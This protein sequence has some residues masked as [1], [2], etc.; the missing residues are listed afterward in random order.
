MKHISDVLKMLLVF[1]I[2]MIAFYKCEAQGHNPPQRINAWYE[3]TGVTTDSV[4]GMP[5]T[6]TPVF[7]RRTGSYYWNTS[8]SNIY[9]WSGSQFLCA[10][11]V[12]NWDKVLSLGG[13]LTAHRNFSFRDSA[14]IIDSSN[15]I[16]KTAGADVPF[17]TPFTI[18]NRDSSQG[19]VLQSFIQ[20]NIYNTSPLSQNVPFTFNMQNVSNGDGT[21]NNVMGFGWNAFQSQSGANAFYYALEPDFVSGGVRY[22]EAHLQFDFPNG[23]DQVRLYSCTFQPRSGISTATGTW[24]FRSNTFTLSTPQNTPYFVSSPGQTTIQG[25]TPSISLIDNV[26][27]ANANFQN[28][29]NVLELGT[30]PLIIFGNSGGKNLTLENFGGSNGQSAMTWQMDDGNQQFLQVTASASTNSQGARAFYLDRPYSSN[31]NPFVIYNSGNTGVGVCS[32]VTDNATIVLGVNSVSGG[33]APP[34]MTTTQ[35]LAI[36]SPAEGIHVYDITLHEGF[37]WNGSAW[38]NY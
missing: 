36:V 9:V 11:C 24:D 16:L 8:D 14:L 4:A 2:A 17:T 37:Y 30:T 18:N 26:S 25:N 32:G 22:K 35:R 19:R 6:Q 23:T 3:F 33:F 10:T 31:S 1:L 7:Y 15:L 38:H 5:T 27:G 12:S 20:P 13:H 21:F 28:T 34:R 29:N